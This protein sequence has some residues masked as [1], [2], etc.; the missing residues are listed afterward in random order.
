MVKV[1]FDLSGIKIPK[2]VAGVKVPKKLRKRGKKL[3]AEANSPAG[4]EAIAAG[5][6]IAGAAIA[7]KARAKTEKRAHA[8]GAGAAVPKHGDARPG[9]AGIDPA[10]DPVDQLGKAITA[11]LGALQAFLTKKA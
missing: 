5:L 7:A 4:R 1:D 6:T 8:A 2:Q 9:H 3:L 11:G 10:T